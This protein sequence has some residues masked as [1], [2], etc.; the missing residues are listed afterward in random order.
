[1]RWFEAAPQTLKRPGRAIDVG[2]PQLGREQMPAA[3]DVEGEI[4]VGIVVAVEEPALLMPMQRHVGRVQVEGD[5]PR[6]RAVGL[7]EQVHKQRLDRRAI[8]ANPVIAAGLTRRR[9]LQPVQRAL[10]GEGRAAGTPGLQLTRQEGQHRVMAQ[11]VVVDQILM[12]EG[13]AEHPLADQGRHR[14]LDPLRR[15]RVL[16]ACREAPDQADSPVR[17][18]QQ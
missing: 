6:R 15:P 9:V 5:L 11:L 10:A 18:A 14:V 1:M 4:A 12:A 16:E 13:D 17:G 8:V 7:L 2:P 3:E